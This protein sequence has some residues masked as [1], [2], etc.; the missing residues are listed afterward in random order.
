MRRSRIS[1]ILSKDFMTCDGGKV[2]TKMDVPS[3]MYKS[4]N[5]WKLFLSLRPKL[6]S[7]E[8][9][10]EEEQA[11]TCTTKGRLDCPKYAAISSL[12]HIFACEVCRTPCYMTKQYLHPA[13]AEEQNVLHLT[14]PA[15]F[16]CRLRHVGQ[17]SNVGMGA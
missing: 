1:P 5:L 6:S 11:I 10:S 15:P 17:S 4:I 9:K 13:S 2:T 8:Q 12:G 7:C 3:C 14:Y 16:S